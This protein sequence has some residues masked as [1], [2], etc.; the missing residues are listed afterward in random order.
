MDSI[1]IPD[2]MWEYLKEQDGANIAINYNFGR[3]GRR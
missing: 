1:T 3:L 2:N